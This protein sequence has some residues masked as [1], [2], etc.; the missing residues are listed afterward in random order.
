ME[1]S[2]AS[3]IAYYIRE[4][5]GSLIA[6]YDS[7]NGMRYYHF[8]ELGSTRLITDSAGNVTDKYDYDAYGAVLWHER[9][10]NS[11]DQPYRFVGELGYYTHWQE[12]DFGFR[13][14]GNLFPKQ[15]SA[16]SGGDSRAVVVYATARPPVTPTTMTRDIA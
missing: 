12:P 6:R 5:N 8:D 2:A 7:T 14:F 4:P 13:C 1:D 16:T 15:T 11:I 10:A 9:D 3:S